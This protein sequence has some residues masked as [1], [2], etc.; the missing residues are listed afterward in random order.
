MRLDPDSLQYHRAR[1]YDPLSGRWT[2]E[3]PLGFAAGDSNLYR[4]VH[5]SP[6]NATDSSG[7][8]LFV[9]ATIGGV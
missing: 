8:F 5:N 3:D 6:T 7:H 2:S 4:Y 9:R 1:W